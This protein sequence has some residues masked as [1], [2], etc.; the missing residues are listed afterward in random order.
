M[1]TYKNAASSTLPVPKD[2]YAYCIATTAPQNDI[3]YDTVSSFASSDRLAVACSDD[4]LLILEPETLRVV[5]DGHFRQASRGI[6]SLAKFSGEGASSTFVTAG[7][8]GLVRGWDL[9]STNAVV[10]LAC[11]GGDKDPVATVACNASS[12]TIAVGTELESN[13]PGDVNIYLWDMRKLNEPRNRYSESHTDTITELRFLPYPSNAS[14]V[15]LSGSTDGLVNVFDTSV[16]DEDDAV[17]QVINH[18][19]AIHHAGLLGDDIFALSMDEHLTVYVQQHQDLERSDPSPFVVGDLR[20]HVDCEYAI[21]LLNRDASPLVAVGNHSIN[22]NL[23][24]IP[25]HRSP[26]VSPTWSSVVSDIVTLPGGHGEDVVRDVLVS[27]SLG[28][29][30]TCGED[31]TVRLWVDP[32]ASEYSNRE[33]QSTKRKFDDTTQTVGKRRKSH[34]RAN[35]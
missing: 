26:G 35:P 9:R 15:L 2:T 29:V 23:Q 17:L 25:Q 18:H 24:L 5:P 28:A 4:S 19:G 1:R 27:D 13:G 31:G 8:D 22:Q 34:S 6:T 12:N 10:E 7:R 30:F 33:L 32:M 20:Q 14:N 21:K 16:A 11:P 3:K